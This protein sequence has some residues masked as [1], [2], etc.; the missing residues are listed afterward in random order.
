MTKATITTRILGEIATIMEITTIIPGV[1]II[2][3]IIIPGEI[4]IAIIIII[5]GETMITV[6]IIIPG[7]IAITIIIVPGEIIIA[8]KIILHGEIVIKI[9]TVHGIMVIQ[10]KIIIHLGEII[11]KTKKKIMVI[12]ISIMKEE[13]DVESCLEAGDFAPINEWNR[14][15][16]WQFGCLYTPQ[17]LLDKT[18][19]APF[20]PQYYVDYLTKKYKEIYGL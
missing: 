2:A 17:E 1:I 9:I 10:T 4:T 14:Q 12:I 15:H 20:D 7:E 6:I 8:M 19:K 3:I 16:I 13:V 11:T 18:L 5:P